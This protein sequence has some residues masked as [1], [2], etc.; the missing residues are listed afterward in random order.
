MLE[1][2]KAILVISFDNKNKNYQTWAKKTM[3][4]AMLWGITSYLWKPTQKYP[5][6]A[7]C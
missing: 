6:K 7:K 4:A 1:E 5:R 3:S 2:S